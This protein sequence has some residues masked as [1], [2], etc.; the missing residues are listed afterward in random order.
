MKLNDIVKLL[1]AIPEEGLKEGDEGVI[2][3]VYEAKEEYDVEFA[4]DITVCLYIH[5][6]ALVMPHIPLYPTLPDTPLLVIEDYESGGLNSYIVVHRDY[7]MVDAEI[8][9]HIDMNDVESWL[10]LAR[11][12]LFK[13]QYKD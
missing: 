1:I 5:H 4:N 7:I 13:E 10:R 3:H 11:P 2:V 6:I 12:H 9:S 8:T